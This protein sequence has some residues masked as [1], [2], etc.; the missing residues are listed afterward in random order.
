MVAR[1]YCDSIDWDEMDA[2]GSNTRHV[3]DNG[4]TQ[5][6]FEQVLDAIGPADVEESLSDPEH[7]TALGETDDGRTLRIV[8]EL[9]IDGGFILIRP[10]T[11]YGPTPR[12][13]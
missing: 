12:G 4:V 5:D 13:G 11:A 3:A 9:T 6:E 1:M 10:I 8:F 7:A 2:S